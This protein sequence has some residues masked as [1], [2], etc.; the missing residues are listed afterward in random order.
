MA[1]S[2]SRYLPIIISF[3]K[4]EITTSYHRFLGLTRIGDSGRWR[5]KEKDPLCWHKGDLQTGD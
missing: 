1:L 3:V 4:L 5:A 2:F